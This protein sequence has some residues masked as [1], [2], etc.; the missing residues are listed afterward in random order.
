MVDTGGYPKR[1]LCQRGWVHPPKMV[2]NT[3]DFGFLIS[4]P[5]MTNSPWTLFSC[6]AHPSLNWNS[7][8]VGRISETSRVN[9][10]NLIYN[11]KCLPQ[12]I[13][14]R[15]SC[16]ISRDYFGEWTCPAKVEVKVKYCTHPQKHAAG[17]FH[18]G[19]YF[20]GC[21]PFT[22]NRCFDIQDDSNDIGGVT[23][24]ESWNPWNCWFECLTKNMF[25]SCRTG[26]NLV[27]R[28]KVP[29]W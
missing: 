1:W 14:F 13:L 21:I 27:G 16:D 20:L 8:L 10:W 2:E 22:G 3:W 24:V 19:L 29:N 15:Y 6:W 5:E 28:W 11:S 18:F 12:H 26:K 23:G 9:P 17:T 25:P 7:E 4:F